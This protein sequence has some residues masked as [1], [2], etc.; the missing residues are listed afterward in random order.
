M[1]VREEG[2]ALSVLVLHERLDVQVEALRGRALR[3]LRG[4]LALLKQ[5]GQQGEQWV[6]AFE[7]ASFKW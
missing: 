2:L 6:P 7:K 1:I 3:R 4:Q 5:E